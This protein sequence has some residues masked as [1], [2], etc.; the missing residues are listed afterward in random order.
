MTKFY[1][2]KYVHNQVETPVI[3]DTLQPGVTLDI[4]N[5]LATCGFLYNVVFEL[6]Y[7]SQD[8]KIRLQEHKEVLAQRSVTRLQKNNYHQTEN[9]YI[10]AFS[11]SKYSKLYF[12]VLAI[13]VS[14]FTT[15]DWAQKILAVQQ[16]ESD[17]RYIDDFETLATL[18]VWST[19]FWLLT[20]LHV[21]NRVFA[22]LKYSTHAGPFVTAF[23][24][25][26]FEKLDR[27]CRTSVH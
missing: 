2:S 24:K 16:F 17:F 21:I 5:A 14:I 8:F 9:I 20:F 25:L 11:K 26:I 7:W 23:R 22:S 15:V 13:I 1:Q 27:I 18:E 10:S 6:K 12:V 3:V 4:L 19:F